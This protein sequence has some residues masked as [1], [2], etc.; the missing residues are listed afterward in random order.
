MTGFD[1]SFARS[2]ELLLH[3]MRGCSWI[4]RRISGPLE[5]ILMW[6]PGAYLHIL[7]CMYTTNHEYRKHSDTRGCSS[8]LASC[9]KCGASLKRSII[10]AMMYSLPR[11]RDTD[12]SGRDLKKESSIL[13]VQCPCYA[14]AVQVKVVPPFHLTA[15]LPRTILHRKNAWNLKSK[16]LEGMLSSYMIIQLL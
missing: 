9:G 15:R 16:N 14:D 6:S 11:S 3:M 13:W 7:Y 5:E 12:F 2:S 1:L 10:K 8:Y 4:D